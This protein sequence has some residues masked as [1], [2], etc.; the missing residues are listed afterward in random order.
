MAKIGLVGTSWWSEAMYIPAIK[1]NIVSICG[2]NIEKTKQL[3]SKYNIKNSFSSYKELIDS[4][5]DGVI[6]ASSTE[7]HYEIAKYALLKGKHVLCEKPL[8]CNEDTSLELTKLAEK[9]NLINSISF[10]YYY[11]PA[12]QKLLDIIKFFEIDSIYMSWQAGFMYNINVLNDRYNLIRGNNIIHDVLS[13]Y[14][15][16]VMKID[17]SLKELKLL[18]SY[19]PVIVGE[20]FKMS[21]INALIELIFK[22]KVVGKVE[23]KTDEN[24]SDISPKFKMIQ[25]ITLS[26]K[27]SDQIIYYNNWND[28]LYIKRN[29]I[30]EYLD[31]PIKSYHKTFREKNTMAR[32]FC[33]CIDN[34]KQ[35]PI[36]FRDGYIIDKLFNKMFNE[37]FN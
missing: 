16:M 25:K 23:L 32:Q 13:H 29:N 4:D 5:I 24:I 7:S 17:N 8:T 20:N 3:A 21:P 28:E 10:T 11:L 6:I 37:E 31:D 26:L 22:S 12:F 9:S 14:I 2:R 27:N 15:F 33:F 36:C 35:M 34:L 1:E 30:I 19:T 18:N